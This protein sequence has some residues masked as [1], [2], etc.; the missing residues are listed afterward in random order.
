MTKLEPNLNGTSNCFCK[1]RD[2]TAEKAESFDN[3]FMPLPPLDGAPKDTLEVYAR[4]MRHVRLAPNSNVYIKILSGIQFT[5][6]MMDMP[7]AMVAKML[8]DMGLRAPRG[9][10]PETYLDHVDRT[11]M[12][13][14]WD[15]QIPC[16]SSIDMKR[17]WDD[18]GED[19]FAA[20]Q[21]DYPLVCVPITV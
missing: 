10:F 11:I 13:S 21:K 16:E 6:D 20:F 17:F 8:A 14:G 19:K 12:R 4:F 18:I 15:A 9:A 7:D 1:E 5:A 2:K 3:I